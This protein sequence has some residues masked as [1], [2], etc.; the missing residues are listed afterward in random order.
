MG[1]FSS[2]ELS[3]MGLTCCSENRMVPVV[4]CR[5]IKL[6]KQAISNGEFENATKWQHIDF[7]RIEKV[8]C[9]M[10]EDEQFEFLQYEYTCLYFL[11]CKLDGVNTDEF[12]EECKAL[13]MDPYLFVYYIQGFLLP[14]F[15]KL[16]AQGK[17]H[18]GDKKMELEGYG[19]W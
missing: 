16:R 15:E 4:D 5:L 9:S 10:T 8:F 12:M 13:E 18:E 3:E 2:T 1:I 6:L 19:W 14:H 17:L 11:V 7:G